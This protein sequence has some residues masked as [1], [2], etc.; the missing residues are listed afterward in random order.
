MAKR[1]FELTHGLEIGSDIHKT[2][3]MRDVTA[4][5]II[6]A[7]EDSEQAYVTPRG[8][9]VLSSPTRAMVI[10]LCRVITKIGTISPICEQEL[11]KLNV[12]DL[13]QLEAVYLEMRGVGN[14]AEMG[15]DSE[16]L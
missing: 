8:T 9:I 16:P 10:F 13:A 12:E 4:G 6:R 14:L 2:V 1:T 11:N 5:D 3:E 7:D 15:R